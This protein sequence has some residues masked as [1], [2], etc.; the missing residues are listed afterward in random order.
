VRDFG[1]EITF[2]KESGQRGSFTLH[3]PKVARETGA[4]RALGEVLVDGFAYPRFQGLVEV[5]G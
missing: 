1:P 3:V 4:P 5:V 2:G